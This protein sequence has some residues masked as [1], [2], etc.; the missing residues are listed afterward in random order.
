MQTDT[1]WF[2][3]F[4]FFRDRVERTWKGR[5]LFVFLSKATISVSIMKEF[6]SFSSSFFLSLFRVRID[7]A[8]SGY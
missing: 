2:S 5:I 4:T 8:M 6:I 7:F 1:F 3:M